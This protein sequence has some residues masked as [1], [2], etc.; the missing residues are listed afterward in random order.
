[1]F[2]LGFDCLCLNSGLFLLFGQLRSPQFDDLL[3][4][5]LQLLFADVEKENLMINCTGVVGLTSWA[6]WFLIEERKVTI[7][8]YDYFAGDLNVVRS[9]N[10]RIANEM[11]LV[12]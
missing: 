2:G 11:Q 5:L 3:L 7:K 1:M 9:R 4:L 10:A 12:D 8:R 6:D